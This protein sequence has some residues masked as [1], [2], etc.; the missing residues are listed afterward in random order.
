MKAVKVAPMA[1][2]ID[3]VLPSLTSSGHRVTIVSNNS[4]EAVRLFLDAHDLGDLV[5]GIAA[6]TTADAD[7]LKPS[8]HLLNVAASHLSVGPE[9][10]IMIGDS[11]SSRNF[12]SAVIGFANKPRKLAALLDAGADAVVTKLAALLSEKSDS[13]PGSGVTSRPTHLSHVQTVRILDVCNRDGGV[14]ICL[15]VLRNTKVCR[16]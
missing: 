5:P 8:P 9:E 11:V 16:Y 15:Y 13:T 7:L 1:K 6:R 2:G 12:G 14:R 10:C 3:S 4:E